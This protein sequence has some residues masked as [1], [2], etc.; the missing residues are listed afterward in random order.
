MRLSL[1][2][3]ICAPSQVTGP[4]KNVRVNAI[5]AVALNT[6]AL[7]EQ[8]KVL[9]WGAD[10]GMCPVPVDCQGMSVARLY[11]GCNAHHMAATTV[12]NE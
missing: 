6:L 2:G 9:L 5:A 7:T 4:L 11:S 1:I 12:R 8:G 3:L 10:G